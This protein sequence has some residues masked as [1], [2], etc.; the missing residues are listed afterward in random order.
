MP[1]RKHGLDQ[2]DDL[3]VE[4]A[5][6]SPSMREPVQPILG[7]TASDD[8]F[9]DLTEG[10]WDH[11]KAQALGLLAASALDTP[12]GHLAYLRERIAGAL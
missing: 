12:A 4:T 11:V 7:M 3:M 2:S 8:D 5:F 1:A 6:V 9:A 10:D